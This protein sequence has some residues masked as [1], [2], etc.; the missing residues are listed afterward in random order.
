MYQTDFTVQYQTS[1][2]N[3]QASTAYYSRKTAQDVQARAYELYDDETPFPLYSFIDNDYKVLTEE[4]RASSVLPGPFSWVGGVYF[5]HQNVIQ[6]END[7][8]TV[9]TGA[10]LDTV[11]QNQ[12]FKQYAVFGE[13]SYAI[14]QQLSATAGVRWFK[15]HQTAITQD[16]ELFTV[17]AN[18][19]IPK[20]LLR[21]RFTDDRM[22]YISATEGFRSGGV[23]L[24]DVPG[25]NNTYQPDTTWNYEVG[26][27][28][29]FL[30][31]SLTVD[32]ALYYI[33]W[34]K[35]QTFVARP[36][37]GPF[38]YFVENVSAARSKGA[39]LEV[40]YT[41]PVLRGVT[42]GF[43]GNLTDARYTEDAPFEGPAG[44][45]T[46]AGA[47]Q[48]MECLH[49]VLG[50]NRRL[51]RWIPARRCGTYRTFL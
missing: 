28:S 38:A 49:T 7:Y 9:P 13:L 37:I 19:A 39:E 3:L 45:S 42:V 18:K 25:V 12:L 44:Q 48:Q 8:D 4:A 23:N 14:T 15:E 36:D 6:N 21:Y 46:A 31:R 5:K 29:S 41:P 11:Y 35:L 51:P 27:K 17:D 50:A 10:Y 24:Y 26:S 30:N 47:G 22:V 33:D 1:W 2:A 40:T 16:G 20:A 32:A 34:R 43:S